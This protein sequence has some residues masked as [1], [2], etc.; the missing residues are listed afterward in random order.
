MEVVTYHPERHYPENTRKGQGKW[1]HPVIHA[2]FLW[3]SRVKGV[4]ILLMSPCFLNPILKN[5]WARRSGVPVDCFRK[6]W[7]G[8]VFPSLCGMV[9]AAVPPELYMQE[10]KQRTGGTGT[11]RTCCHPS[12]HLFHSD[13]RVSSGDWA[14]GAVSSYS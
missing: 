6:M 5:H 14:G 8:A 3:A 13:F 9:T 4:R 2:P 1:A 12:V 7:L 11:G 10:T